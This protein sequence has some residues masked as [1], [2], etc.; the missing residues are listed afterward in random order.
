MANFVETQ[1]FKQAW[2]NADRRG[3]D[4]SRVA[5]GL[6]AVDALRKASREVPIPGLLLEYV[7][8]IDYPDYQAE[9]E[10]YN[11]DRQV[12][13]DVDKATVAISMSSEQPERH[14]LVIDLD[15][16]AKLI[17]STT[18]GHYHL[19]VDKLIP[20]DKYFALLK[21]LANA[22]LIEP[23]YLGASEARGYTAVR[24]PWVK[25]KVRDNAE[26]QSGL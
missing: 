14:K 5:A 18:P 21:A 16:P 13:T 15:L 26:A 24:L 3:L 19:Y 10:Q 2:E 17:E 8:G 4:G 11:T 7:P 1:V 9:N 6:D 20:T 22:G 23:G 12:T 25:K